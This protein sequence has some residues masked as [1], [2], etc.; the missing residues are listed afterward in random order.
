MLNDLIAFKKIKEGDIGTFEEVF[1]RYYAPLHLYSFSI[2][3]R[4][5]ISEE[6]IQ[7]LFYTIW[8]DRE[9]L[10]ILRSVKNY[11]YGAVRNR[12]LQYI[13]HRNVQERHKEATLYQ[14][15]ELY[16]PTPHE[17]LEYKELE[18]VINRTLEQLPERRLKIFRMHRME[19]KKYKEIADY[20]SV[21]VKTVE[22]EMTKAYQI[23]RQEIERYTHIL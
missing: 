4:R 9:N 5:D 15:N 7:D 10:N 18:E 23:L 16:D 2:T 19:G 17:Q 8:K 14:E 3:G 11:L 12:S 22:A 20:F 21:S 6:I 13:E 1:R